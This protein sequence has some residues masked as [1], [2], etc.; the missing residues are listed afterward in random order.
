MADRYAA[1]PSFADD[2]PVRDQGGDDQVEIDDDDSFRADVPDDEAQTAS[3]R[4][5]ATGRGRVVPESHRP[6]GQSDAAGR[7]QPVRQPRS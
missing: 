2:M 6:V 5:A 7:Q 1:V 3:S 4:P